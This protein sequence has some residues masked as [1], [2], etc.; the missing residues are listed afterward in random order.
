MRAV[1]SADLRNLKLLDG[2]FKRRNCRLS[3]YGFVCHEPILCR[4]RHALAYPS[5]VLSPDAN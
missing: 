2:S 1:S 4:Q 5:E 3:L